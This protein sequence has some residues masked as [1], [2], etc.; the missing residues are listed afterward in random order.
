MGWGR[1]VEVCVHRA[2][3]RGGGVSLVT[4]VLRRPHAFLVCLGPASEPHGA[5][6]HASPD[7]DVMRLNQQEDAISATCDGARALFIVPLVSWTHE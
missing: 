5:V 6:P 1:G 7:M 2:I 4:P 3:V